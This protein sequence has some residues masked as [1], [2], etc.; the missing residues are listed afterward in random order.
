LSKILK[1]NISPLNVPD[2]TPAN[3]IRDLCQNALDDQSTF[4]YSYSNG[5]LE[6]T[7]K[8][9]KLNPSVWVVGVSSKRGDPNTVGE[10]GEGLVVA[11]QVLLRDGFKVT[12]INSDETWY[13]SIQYSEVFETDC[14]EIEISNA[15]F[16]NDYTVIIEGVSEELWQQVVHD[17]LYLRDEDSLG[18]YVTA[19]CGSRIFYDI[20]NELYVGGLYVCKTQLSFSYDL[21][22][23]K[24]KLNRDRMAVSDWDLQGVTAR[25]LNSVTDEPSFLERVVGIARTGGNDTYHMKYYGTPEGSED[26]AYAQF[27]ESYGEDK[28]VATDWS[29]RENLVKQGYDEEKIVVVSQ[30]SYAKM[31]RGSSEYKEF[32]DSVEVVEEEETDD[33]SPVEVL[34]GLLETY[35]YCMDTATEEALGLAVKLFKLR[36]VSWDDSKSHRLDSIPF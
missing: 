5:V 2:W 9:V 24:M 34:E 15:G 27:K 6:L 20:P 26:I 1:T 19:P 23:S 16:S 17:C 29:D 28:I 25:I 14:L 3:A 30:E 8:G 13:P 36:G 31:V 12:I 21:H 10:K 22:P 35:E 18:D 4:E 32:L 33:R 11:T 7:S